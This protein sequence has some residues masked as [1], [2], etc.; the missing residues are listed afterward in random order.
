MQINGISETKAALLSKKI[1]NALFEHDK[2][3]FSGT[4]INQ[5]GVTMGRASTLLRIE[6]A[7]QSVFSI[8]PNQAQ[9]GSYEEHLALVIGKKGDQYIYLSWPMAKAITHYCLKNVI[10][11]KDFLVDDLIECFH[12]KTLYIRTSETY[13]MVSLEGKVFE[14]TN[15]DLQTIIEESHGNS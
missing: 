11:V 12:L 13:R 10:E 1:K 8:D 6:N 14:Y 4:L 9:A 7:I 15:E 5:R 2:A 3:Y